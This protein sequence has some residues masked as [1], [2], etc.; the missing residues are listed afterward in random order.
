MN[1]LILIITFVFLIS[2]NAFSQTEVEFLPSDWENPAVFEKGQTAPHAF[3]IPYDFVDNA[4]KNK[5]SPNY[6]LLNGLWKFKLAETPEQ[7]PTDFWKPKFDVEDWAEIKVPSNWQ[8]EGYDHSKFRNIALTFESDPP[9][10]PDYFNPTGCYKRKFTIPKTWEAKE[11][12]LRFEGIKSASYIWVNGKR[13]GYNQGGF[14][15][16]EFNIT[17]FIEK[18]ENDLAVQVMRFSDGSYLENQDMWRLSGIYR[19]VKLY[20]L[21]KT[22]IHDFYVVTDFDKNYKDATLTVE[23][24]IINTIPDS[25]VCTLSVNVFDKNL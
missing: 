21:P 7:V 19:D 24:D 18:G 9:K 23:T 2:L 10:I 25:A 4:L 11:I 17:P 22:Y 8:M 13:V 20:A 14:E 3:Y 12:M 5:K 15:P 16:A 6:Q 1:R